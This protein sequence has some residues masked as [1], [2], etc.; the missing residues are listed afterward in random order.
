MAGDS[1]VADA[2]TRSP[3]RQAIWVVVTFVAVWLAVAAYWKTTHHLPSIRELLLSGIGVP[4]LLV[5]GIVSIRK[6]FNPVHRPTPKRAPQIADTAAETPDGDPARNWTMALLDASMRLPAGMNVDEVLALARDGKVVGLHPTLRRLDGAKVF[7]GSAES[8]WR[9]D[10]DDGMLA[11]GAKASGN[12]EQ[13]R[14]MLLAAETI[15]ELMQRHATTPVASPK[16]ALQA[17]VPPFQL[18]LLLPERWRADAPTLTAWLDRHLARGH[19]QPG[20]APAK[21]VIVAHSIEALE[22]LDALNVELNQQPSTSRH[23]VL[24]CD[25][26]LS[27]QTVDLLDAAGRLFAHD[28]PDGQIPGEGACALLLA[29]PT[30]AS[31]S[32]TAQIHRLVVA[33][34]PM[35]DTRTGQPNGDTVAG[36][37]Q[38]ALAQSSHPDLAIADCALVSDAD[39]R[40]SS[41]AEISDA[42]RQ[43]WPAD[44]DTRPR[45]H[46]LGIANG[47][48]GAVLALSTIAAA[49]A[50]SVAAR[51]STLAVSIG[52][53]TIRSALLVSHP[54]PLG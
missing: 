37:L 1:P 44:V 25:S 26:T 12:D 40:I 3:V 16:D 28:H 18:H 43:A 21:T 11:L 46:H 30:A 24:A 49:G 2:S 13:R 51:Q 36:L 42:A 6:S 20:V 4:L 34:L 7:A 15:D 29:L 54:A 39:Q 22:A 33:E 14:A 45:C 17:E 9:D 23:I 41:R 35:S 31:A 53:P 5:I 32:D 10:F 47:D 52:A 27:Q 38:K 50:H 19:W 8:I 48:S